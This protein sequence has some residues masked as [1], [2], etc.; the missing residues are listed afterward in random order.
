MT[1]PMD[2]VLVRHGESEG[3]VVY[4]LARQG[5]HALFTPEFLSRHSSRWRLT[6]LGVRHFHF[7]VLACGV[8]ITLQPEA[9]RTYTPRVVN[10]WPN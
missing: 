2:L 3:N 9:P 10:P 1:M 4:G 8:T 6:R 7:P 5:D